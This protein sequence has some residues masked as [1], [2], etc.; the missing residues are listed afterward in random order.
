MLMAASRCSRAPK[1][2]I[3]EITVAGKAG[4]LL[5]SAKEIDINECLI[6][7]EEMLTAANTP[8]VVE[9]KKQKKN[10]YPDAHTHTHTH[11]EEAELIFCTHVGV[12]YAQTHR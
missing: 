11:T 8:Q 2:G 5:H 7:G 3:D 4:N 1:A 12:L 6:A 9:E 10:T